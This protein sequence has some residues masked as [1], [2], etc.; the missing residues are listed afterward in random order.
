MSRPLVSPRT[1]SRSPRPVVAVRVP[2]EVA[3]G[4]LHERVLTDVGHQLLEHAGALGVG[5]AVEV[6]L[7]VL[8]VAD[9]GGDRVRGGQ[10]VRAVGPGLAA[11][12][13]GDPGVGEARRADAGEGAHEVGEGLLQPQVVPPH[14]GDEV[15]EPHVGHLVQDDVRPRLVGG[16]RHLP[17][18]DVLLAEGHQARVLHRAEVVLGHE[19]LVVLAEGVRVVEVVVEEVQAL[20]RDQEDVVGV[21][22]GGQPLAAH[23]AEGD[24]QRRAVAQVAR[25]RVRHVVV[26]AGHDTGDVRRDRLRLREPPD[27]VRALAGAVAPHRPFLGRAHLEAE[28]GLEVGLLEGDEDPARVGGLVLRVEVDLAVLRVDEAVQALARAGVRAPGVHHQ[29]VLRR[30]VLQQDPGAVEDLAG[31]EVA[32]VEGDGRH[33]RRD[34]VGEGRRAGLVAAEPDRGDRPE[35]AWR[36]PGVVVDRRT[37][38]EGHVVSVDGQ[39]GGPLPGLVAGQVLTGHGRYSLTAWRMGL[40]TGAILPCAPDTGRQGMCGT[41]RGVERESCVC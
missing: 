29:L 2:L 4:A 21:E 8:K 25:V 19:R 22:V 6:E 12:G 18:E 24:L 35:G 7:G 3:A 10:L 30:Q 32:A 20:P 38:V 31:V 11:V 17:P 34:Q 13:E 26:G 41:G 15:A 28:G 1:D 27:P 33:T 9:V 40:R 37:D 23:R 39:Q 36:V 5:D 16:L 14:H